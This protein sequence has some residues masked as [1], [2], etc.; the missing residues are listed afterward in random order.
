MSL[1]MFNGE[2]QGFYSYGGQQSGDHPMQTSLSFQDNGVVMGSGRDDV[3]VFHFRG[4]CHME[5]LTVQLIK[6][7]PTHQVRYTGVL[8]EGPSGITIS[9]IWSLAGVYQSKGGFTLRK[10]KPAQSV[11]ADIDQLEK[12]LQKSVE[13]IEEVRIQIFEDQL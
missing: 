7:Y 5:T 2:Y 8:E 9:G 1:S 3:N 6:Q 11:M 12:E 4:T 10:S 13:K